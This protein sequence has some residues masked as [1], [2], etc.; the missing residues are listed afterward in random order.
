MQA[1]ARRKAQLDLPTGR[2]YATLRVWAAKMRDGG[3]AELR[4][5]ARLLVTILENYDRY[6]GRPQIAAALWESV[7]LMAASMRKK[8]GAGA[9]T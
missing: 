5:E 6:R 4:D 2:E 7:R 8:F 9:T 1:P 3:P